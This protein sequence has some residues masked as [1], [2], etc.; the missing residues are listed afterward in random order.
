V[1]RRATTPLVTPTPVAA[2]R[3]ARRRAAVGVLWQT[4]RSG[5]RPGTPGVGERLSSLPAMTR[6]ALAGRYAGPGRT[7]LG[8]AV[9]GLVYL[10]SP[11]DV[12]PE[13]FLPIVGL[14][15]DAVVAAWVAGSVLVATEDYAAW[16]SGAA[17]AP[18]Q[19]R[20]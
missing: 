5:T 17:P 8:L 19:P 7:R 18:E 11:L 14:V 1:A 16:R 9:A 10:V 15:D 4:L 12:L 6:D 20:S 2:P 13:A 3:P